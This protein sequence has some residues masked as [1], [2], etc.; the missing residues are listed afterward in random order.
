MDWLGDQQPVIERR[1]TK[2]YLHDPAQPMMALFDLSSSW[3]TSTKNPLAR[4]A[5]CGH[6]QSKLLLSDSLHVIA[7]IRVL[8]PRPF[9]SRFR[10]RMRPEAFF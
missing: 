1:L 10:L 6:Q 9:T 5:K 4:D 7:V 8:G 3:V 2:R